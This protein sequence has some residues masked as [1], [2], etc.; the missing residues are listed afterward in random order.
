M[1]SFTY[2]PEQR[3]PASNWF[4]EQF[5][6]NNSCLRNVY[7][8]IEQWNIA[9]FVSGPAGEEGNSRAQAIA[10]AK[11]QTQVTDGF[12]V[13]DTHKLGETVE[14]LRL[15]TEVIIEA[16]QVSM[17]AIPVFLDSSSSA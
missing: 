3:L 7:Y 5:R 17:A 14:Y 6:L 10:T 16:H 15:L 13:K 8:I 2:S 12:F 1:R 11:S 9:N 4:A